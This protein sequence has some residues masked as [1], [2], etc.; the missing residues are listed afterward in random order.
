[1]NELDSVGDIVTGGLIAGAI[2]PSTGVGGSRG[3]GAC[4]N[5]RT[6]L[7]GPYCATC[8]QNC[9]GNSFFDDGME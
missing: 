9:V 1:M 8:G 7:T 2:E 5:C 4:L 3:E 6:L